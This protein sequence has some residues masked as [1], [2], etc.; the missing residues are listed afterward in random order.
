MLQS[1]GLYRAG[2]DCVLNS[3]NHSNGRKYEEELKTLLKMINEESEKGG[4]KQ[5]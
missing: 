3:N 4:L 5:H 2:H 1:M